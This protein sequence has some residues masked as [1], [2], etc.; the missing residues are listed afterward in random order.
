MR[1]ALWRLVI[2]RSRISWIHGKGTAECIIL[3]CGR[4]IHYQ[5]PRWYW[6]RMYMRPGCLRGTITNIP[7]S[8]GLSGG[9]IRMGLLTLFCFRSRGTPGR[10]S[11]MSCPARLIRTGMRGLCSPCGLLAPTCLPSASG[12]GRGCWR[13]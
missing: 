5:R 2:T 7:T 13:A 3:Y 4:G 1:Q 12:S 8:Q 9:S 6:I 11:R 10:G